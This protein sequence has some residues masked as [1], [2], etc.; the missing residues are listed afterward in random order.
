MDDPTEP[1][2][3]ASPPP[4]P[5]AATTARASQRGGG[6]GTATAP[7]AQEATEALATLVAAVE[8]VVT[9][10]RQ[11]VERCV[12]VFAAGGH[13]LLQDV[14]GVGKTVLARAL[15][16]S[17]DA[18]FQR[19]Q[20]A[21]DLLPADITGSNVWDPGMRD[22]RFVPGPV[23]AQ[24]VLVDELNRTTPRT[25]AALLEAMEEGQVTVDGTTHPL[26]RPHMV[27][28]TQNPAEH[29]GTFALPESQLDRF[30]VSTSLGYPSESDEATIVT[31]QML[32]HPLDT[33]TPVLDVDAVLRLRAAVRRVHVA[34]PVVR[35]GVALVRA[36]RAG[37]ALGASPRASVQLLRLAQA[38]ALLR[39][40]DHVLPDD[41]KLL[42]PDVLTHRVM[43]ADGRAASE[44]VAEAVARVP[45][46]A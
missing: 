19:V 10:K 31:D 43:P 32:A 7:A 39:G 40:R 23:F 25:Q 22:F 33:V 36:T 30:M 41:C 34:D 37:T 35:Y 28:A 12:T 45:V 20:G 14:P 13:V 26:P 44:I 15:A 42:A 4:P 46:P 9:G 18:R 17:V 21:P 16:R 27:V 24:V 1:R 11:V 6:P 3:P 5:A 29:L 38:T 2:A 8:R